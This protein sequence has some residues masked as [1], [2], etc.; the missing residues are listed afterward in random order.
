MPTR[1]FVRDSVRI[2]RDRELM[3]E[4]HVLRPA[5]TKANEDRMLKVIRTLAAATHVLPFSTAPRETVRAPDSFF[6]VTPWLGEAHDQELGI[7]TS[8]RLAHNNN[9]HRAIWDS[10]VQI[11]VVDDAVPPPTETTRQYVIGR[12]TIYEGSD[13]LV[14]YASSHEDSGLPGTQSWADLQ[15]DLQNAVAELPVPA[16]P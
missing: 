8:L 1:N 12:F 2:D 4:D 3:K 9:G 15:Y 13:Q 14:G 16:T 5:P 11:D 10:I 6:N 7:Y